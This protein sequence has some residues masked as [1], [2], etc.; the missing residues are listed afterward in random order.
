MIERRAREGSW[1]VGAE[2]EDRQT[3]ENNGKNYQITCWVTSVMQAQTAHVAAFLCP[4]VLPIGGFEG[5]KHS[6]VS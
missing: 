5:D 3:T 2:K 6:L 1:A 4:S